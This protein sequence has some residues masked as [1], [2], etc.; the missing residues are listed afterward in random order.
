MVFA[1]VD[2]SAGHRGITAFLVERDMPGF[3]A[4]EQRDLALL[5]LGCRGGLD[6][7]AP[8]LGDARFRARLLA[9]KQRRAALWPKQHERFST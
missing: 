6:K 3:S 2:P 7:M 5:V 9:L 1:T 8:V 4:G